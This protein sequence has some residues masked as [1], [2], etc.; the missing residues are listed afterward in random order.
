MIGIMTESGLEEGA[1]EE[2][3]RRE[4]F[5]DHLEQRKQEGSDRGAVTLRQEKPDDGAREAG[6]EWEG[7]QKNEADLQDQTKARLEE[8]RQTSRQLCK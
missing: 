4:E 6:E 1:E 5:K 7:M 2:M 3:W 8:E